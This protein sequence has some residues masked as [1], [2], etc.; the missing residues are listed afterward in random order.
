M[1]ATISATQS[2][3]NGYKQYNKINESDWWW[4]YIAFDVPNGIL[5]AGETL[6]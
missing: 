1:K 3:K 2:I 4:W 6:Y 5:K